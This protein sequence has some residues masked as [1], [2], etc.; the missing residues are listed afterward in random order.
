MVRAFRN[1]EYQEVVDEFDRILRDYPSHTKGSDDLYYLGLSYFFLERNAQALKTLLEFQ[2]RFHD[3][4][5]VAEVHL[6]VARLF[7]RLGRPERS[8]DSLRQTIHRA[9]DDALRLEAWIEKADILAGD[10]RYLESLS[11]LDEAYRRSVGEQRGEALARIRDLLRVMPEETV[12]RLLQGWGYSFPKE[13][14]ERVLPGGWSGD[15]FFTEA[16]E[17]AVAVE[18]TDGP[19]KK[20]GVLAPPGGRLEAY[21]REIVRGVELL[22]ET[23]ADE[24]FPYDIEIV[25][26]EEGAESD[27]AFLVGEQVR[28]EDILVLIGPLLSSTVERI[29]PAAESASLAVLSPTASSARLNGI[30]ANFFRNC[31]T[32]EESGKALADLAVKVL[33]LRTFVI[34]TPDDAYGFHYADIFQRE[35]EARGGE[36]IATQEYNVELTDFARPIKALKAKAGVPERREGEAG[37]EETGGMV[38]EEHTLPFEAIFL[39][40][41]A[42][43][44]GLILPQFAFHD[45]DVRRLTVLGGS[46]LNTPRFPKVGEEFAEGAFFTDGF[47][48]GSPE[49]PVQLFVSDY[50]G[51]YGE[52]PGTFAA[53]AYDAAAIVLELL[54]RGADTREKMLRALGEVEDF[55]GVTG[56]TTL[57]PGGYAGR[58]PFFGTVV[59]GALVSL[60]L[61]P[62]EYLPVPE[63]PPESPL[64]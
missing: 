17:T 1:G 49:R 24:S 60:E 52:S 44:V 15:G 39:P 38:E 37:G 26:I 56:R 55:A 27:E 47:F 7:R 46:G 28:S 16:P 19:L 35:V 63:T 32:L 51:K 45:M 43:E 20:I 31:L 54:R 41:S 6:T 11:V 3:D 62:Y 48:A 2:Y 21:G 23:N 9:T 40:G 10:G 58:E 4:L 34:F 42:E 12:A 29:M 22:V 53:Q 14:G 36:V 25:F 64:P 57:V 30:S 13:E 5:R 61:L 18:G 59:R 50:R 33:G 8:L